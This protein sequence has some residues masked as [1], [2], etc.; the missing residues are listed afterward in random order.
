[1]SKISKEFEDVRND[2]F[3]SLAKPDTL[4]LPVSQ[5]RPL[6]SHLNVEL[7]EECESIYIYI[8]IVI[9]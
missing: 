1:M 6:H 7:T 3:M 5:L 4:E 8:F 9:I 2:L